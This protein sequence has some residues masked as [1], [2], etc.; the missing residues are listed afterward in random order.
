MDIEDFPSTN[1]Q[2]PS[3]PIYQIYQSTCVYTAGRLRR[4]IS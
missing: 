4:M 1:C 3:L 2:C